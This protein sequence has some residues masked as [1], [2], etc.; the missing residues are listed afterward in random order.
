MTNHK[1]VLMNIKAL[2]LKLLNLNFSYLKTKLSMCVNFNI[3][4]LDCVTKH[5]FDLICKTKI[6]IKTSVIID[7]L[8]SQDETSELI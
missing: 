2:P 7:N 3:L 1:I 5:V 8:S 4:P 6:L